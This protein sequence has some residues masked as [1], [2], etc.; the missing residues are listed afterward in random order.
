M[1][2]NP[3]HKPPLIQPGDELIWIISCPADPSRSD[4]KK[5]VYMFGLIA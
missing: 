4:P 5:P 3:L 1:D 2:I